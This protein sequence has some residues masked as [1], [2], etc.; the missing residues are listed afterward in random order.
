MIRIPEKPYMSIREAARFT[1]LS[2]SLLRGMQ[3]RGTLPGIFSGRKFCVNVPALLAQIE[4]RNTGA[5]A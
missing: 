3:K 5:S 2:E 1:G 4:N